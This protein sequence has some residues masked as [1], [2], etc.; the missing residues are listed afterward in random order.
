[1]LAPLPR[2]TS[3]CSGSRWGAASR[4]RRLSIGPEPQRAP[5][6]PKTKFGSE[7]PAPFSD[8]PEGVRTKRS[9]PDARSRCSVSSEF[10]PLISRPRVR[11]LYNGY[12]PAEPERGVSSR[13]RFSFQLERHGVHGDGT[14]TYME[15]AN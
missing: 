11:I 6:G 3:L 1:M 2:E 14:T 7:L 4:R 10:P 15:F 5:R 12:L 9:R 8:L 13:S